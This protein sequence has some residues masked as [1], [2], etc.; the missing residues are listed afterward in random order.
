MEIDKYNNTN[1]AFRQ[2]P[3]YNNLK[4]HIRTWVIK[5][6]VPRLRNPPEW[7]EVWKSEEY[8]IKPLDSFKDS[9]SEEFKR[10]TNPLIA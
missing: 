8:L 6:I 7:K 10:M 4:S 3:H 9:Y 1:E 2:G 5:S